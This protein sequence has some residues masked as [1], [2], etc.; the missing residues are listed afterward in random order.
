MCAAVPVSVIAARAQMEVLV[1]RVTEPLAEHDGGRTLPCPHGAGDDTSR[2]QFYLA[3]PSA[4]GKSKLSHRLWDNWRRLIPLMVVDLP[5]GRRS[6]LLEKVKEPVD[7]WASRSTRHRPSLKQLHKH[8]TML[9][10][11]ARCCSSPATTESPASTSSSASPWGRRATSRPRRRRRR[12]LLPPAPPAPPL[13][14]Q[15]RARGPRDLPS[16]SLPRD[17]R[18][19]TSLSPALVTTAGALKSR[20]RAAGSR[21][22]RRPPGTSAP[23]AADGRR[24]APSPGANERGHCLR[25]HSP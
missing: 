15:P 5:R 6:V 8:K 20:E 7:C 24:A 11:S 17:G 22:G 12:G 10:V 1:A 23:V 3:H 13:Q 19:P 14:R 21:S 25:G 16:G 2:S 9:Y 18:G 4:D